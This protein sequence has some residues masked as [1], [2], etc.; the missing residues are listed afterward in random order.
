MT[1]RHLRRRQRMTACRLTGAAAVLAL[2]TAHATAANGAVVAASVLAQGGATLTA[3]SATLNG[4]VFDGVVTVPT[5]SGDVRVVKLTSTA[6]A[7]TNLRLRLPCTAIQGLGAGMQSESVTPNGSTA[8]AASGLTLYSP[9]VT[10]TTAG[11][12]VTWTPDSP[13]PAQA[14]GDTTLTDLTVELTGLTVPAFSVPGLRQATSFCT[15]A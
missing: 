5:S 8:K 1:P 11:T 4:L 13:P 3:S 10:A 12:T 14:L 7:L 9:S 15:P 2:L 6:A